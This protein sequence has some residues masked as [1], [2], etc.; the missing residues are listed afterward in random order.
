MKDSRA[1]YLVRQPYYDAENLYV[2]TKPSAGYDPSANTFAIERSTFTN[3]ALK[4]QLRKGT[5]DCEC[6]YVDTA[7]T[8]SNVIMGS[9]L[10]FNQPVQFTLQGCE[11]THENY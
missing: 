10:V 1:V 4:C 3:L 2:G 5:C 8:R 7:V 6:A 11:I 9:G